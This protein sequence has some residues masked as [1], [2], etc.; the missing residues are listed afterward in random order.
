MKIIFLSGKYVFAS[1]FAV[2]GLIHFGPLEFSIDYVP[3]FLPWPA[4]WVYFSGICLI[5][6]SLSAWLG[7]KDQLAAFLL[8]LMLLLFVMLI[9]VPH[10]IAG[11]FTGAIAMF[12]DLAMGGAALMYAG[13]FAKDKFVK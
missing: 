5:A 6:F 9:H 2:F 11:D 1:M 8:T 3:E 7:K 10:A 13:A 4:I 12:R